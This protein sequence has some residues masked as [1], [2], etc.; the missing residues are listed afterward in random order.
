MRGFTLA[1]C[2]VTMTIYLNPEPI[3]IPENTVASKMQLEGTSFG[4]RIPDFYVL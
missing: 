4:H 2:E 1:L 3:Y